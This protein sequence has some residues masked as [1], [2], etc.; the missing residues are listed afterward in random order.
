[1]RL[2]QLYL[3]KTHRYHH[4]LR[5]TAHLRSRSLHRRNPVKQQLLL[6]KMQLQ[7]SL[8]Q[9]LRHQLEVVILTLLNHHQPLQDLQATPQTQR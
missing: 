6:V 5:P 3:Y 4:L 9:A 7:S 8:L 2:H 1:V